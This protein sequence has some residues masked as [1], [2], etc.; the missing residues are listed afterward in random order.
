MSMSLSMQAGEAKETM[1]AGFSE[2]IAMSEARNAK[3]VEEE[4]NASLEDGEHAIDM[5]EAKDNDNDNGGKITLAKSQSTTATANIAE[6]KSPD[7][8]ETTT[9]EST[10]VAATTSTTATATA[11]PSETS[12]TTT[13]TTTTTTTNNGPEIN[14]EGERASL[15]EDDDTLA[16]NQHPRNEMATDIILLSSSELTHPIRFWLAPFVS[17]VLASLKRASFRSAQKK[18]MP[19]MTMIGVG[20]KNEKIKRRRRRGKTKAK[21]GT[22]TMEVQAKKLKNPRPHPTSNRLARFT[23]LRPCGSRRLN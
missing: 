16:M 2:A 5:A 12:S 1:G 17:L 4:L 9:V 14:N 6:S 20:Q 19:M 7:P 13:N 8:E 21:K 23:I 11:T 15:D 10:T 18:A 3:M 22:M